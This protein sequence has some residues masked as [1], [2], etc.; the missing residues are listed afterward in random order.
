MSKQETRNRILDAA[1]RLFN[2]HGTAAISTN[3]IAREAGVSPGNLYYHYRNKEEIIREI[4]ERMFSAWGGAWHRSD[5]PAVSLQGLRIVI[6]LN[7]QLLWEYRFFYRE[8]VALMLR[9]PILA[10]RHAEMQQQRLAD[11]D[12]FYQQFVAAGIFRQPADTREI[13]DLVRTTW[14]L[15]VNWLPFLESGGQRVTE[16]RMHEGERI[17]MR[18]FR[19]YLTDAALNELETDATRF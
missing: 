8:A 6:R 4:L 18:I 5:V 14:I 12:S 13:A 10:E 3:H 16:E 1:V 2:E 7:F 11:Q 19:G 15:G 17:I 9:D